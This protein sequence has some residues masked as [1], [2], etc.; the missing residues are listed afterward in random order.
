[1]QFS[2]SLITLR[3]PEPEDLELLYEWENLAQ[4]WETGNTRQPYSR[5][6]LKQYID[7]CHLDAPISSSLKKILFLIP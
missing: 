6:A 4:Y 5:Y 3:A 7:Q 2:N 1:M